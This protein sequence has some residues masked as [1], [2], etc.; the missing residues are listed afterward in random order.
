M[1]LSLLN[2]INA[3]RAKEPLAVLGQCQLKISVPETQRSIMADFI[4]VPEAQ[5]S[6]LSNQT[7]KELGVL[8]IGI[9]VN[10]YSLSQ[11]D[12]LKG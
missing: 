2:W 3:P 7:S 9:N 1:S 12:P 11:W 6:L 4:V 8:S 10:L 5:V